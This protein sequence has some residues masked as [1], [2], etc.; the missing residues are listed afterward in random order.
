MQ[1]RGHTD[2]KQIRFFLFC[3]GFCHSP[4][5]EN[6]KIIMSRRVVVEDFFHVDRGFL[7]DMLLLR[8]KTVRSLHGCSRGN[9]ICNHFITK[10]IV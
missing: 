4:N 9:D 7:Q 3:D 6:V 2:H 1:Q 10:D 8:R 5:P